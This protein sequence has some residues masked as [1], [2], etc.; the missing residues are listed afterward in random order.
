[1]FR[2]FLRRFIGGRPN[3]DVRCRDCRYF[4]R[5]PQRDNFYSSNLRRCRK[6]GRL[7]WAGDEAENC[8]RFDFREDSEE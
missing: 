2:E 1:M 7:H 4:D 8:D 6:D 3:K 5:P